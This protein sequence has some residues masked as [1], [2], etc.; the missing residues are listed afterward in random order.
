[1]LSIVSPLFSQIDNYPKYRELINQAE[2]Q[3]IANE[4]ESAL[5]T[6]QAAFS[7][8]KGNHVKDIHNSLQL[9]YELDQNDTLFKLL[10]L[11]I[12]KDLDSKIIKR[13]FYK[14][15]ND[16]RWTDF[17]VRNDVYKAP[18]R[19]FKHLFDSLHSIDQEF[20]MKVGSYEKYGDT[21]NSIDSMNYLFI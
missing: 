4:K 10:D 14:Y 12:I 20:R 21:I 1:M 15:H 16:P 19:L 11:M 7:S 13:K 8:V 2:S 5:T 6:Y 9:A 17:I 18:K 3:L